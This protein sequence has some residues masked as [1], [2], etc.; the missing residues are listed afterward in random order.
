MGIRR[1]ISG[2]IW[3]GVLAVLIG[4][5]LRPA[6]LRAAAL[7]ISENWNGVTSADR[8]Y[9]EH[10]A[11]T[12]NDWGAT[13]Y[14]AAWVDGITEAVTDSDYPT[15][16]VTA[17][18]RIWSPPWFCGTITGKS[19]HW[20]IDGYTWIELEEHLTDTDYVVCEI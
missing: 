12:W 8:E 2:M 9:V 19:N 6:S 18:M 4:G 20:L 14:V 17:N 3:A 13:S 11:W 7:R 15:A 16:E 10:D 1:M 5:V